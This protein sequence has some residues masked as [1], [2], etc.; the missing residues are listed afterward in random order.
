MRQLFTPLILLP[1]YTYCD[2]VHFEIVDSK[3]WSQVGGWAQ[4]GDEMDPAGSGHN[5]MSRFDET[6]V[7]SLE[8]GWYDDDIDLWY[9]FTAPNEGLYSIE[10]L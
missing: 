5:V 4:D 1:F 10:L 7:H 6:S 2:V 3:L 8:C 9:S